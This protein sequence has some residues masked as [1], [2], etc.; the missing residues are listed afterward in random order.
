[1]FRS[2]KVCLKQYT[3]L[4]S[5]YYQLRNSLADYILPSH[6]R[7]VVNYIKDK[8]NSIVLAGHQKSGNTWAR[9]VVYNYF[10]ILL[11]NARETLT[12]DELNSIQCHTLERGETD[13]FR[14]GFPVLYR[15][16]L[17][18]VR[19]FSYFSNAIYVYRNP[20]DVLISLYYF[21][22]NRTVP[23]QGYTALEK[24]RLQDINYFVLYHLTRW[25]FHYRST[26]Y[27][28]DIV[29]SYERMKQ[30]TFG[31][32]VVAFN[33]LGFNTDEDALRQSIEMS[34]F[35]NIR[36]MGRETGQLSGNTGK[37]LIGE[38]TRSGETNQYLSELE[39]STIETARKMLLRNG[40]DI[41]L[42]AKQS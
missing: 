2:L 7:K 14:P 26:R 4:H 27:K 12:Y 11:N 32:F 30:D 22:K 38:F 19:A 6:H 13:S 21:Q 18:Y 10:N 35:E 15:T 20:L 8:E 9:F 16:H 24:N 28:S 31:E 33:I 39:S 34:S 41:E 25:I 1:M 29:L 3:L 42:A 23:F 17:P 5:L 40:I 36:R 37:T